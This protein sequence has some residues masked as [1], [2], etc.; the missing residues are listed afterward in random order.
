MKKTMDKPE[1]NETDLKDM[2]GVNQLARSGDRRLKV[3]CYAVKDALLSIYAEPDGF[4][5]QIWE[6]EGNECVKCGE[7]WMSCDC[8]ETI[9][10]THAVHKHILERMKI[11]ESV[12]HRPTPEFYYFNAKF[13]SEKH[14]PNFF[15]GGFQIKNTIEG[16]TKTPQGF[17]R[18][19]AFNSLKRLCRKFKPILRKK[20]PK[21]TRDKFW[22]LNL[23]SCME[24]EFYF[25]SARLP[26]EV[27]AC[28]GCGKK[29]WLR[30]W[31][32][33]DDMEQPHER[34][35]QLLL[36]NRYNTECD[37]NCYLPLQ[38]QKT[39]WERI[40]KWLDNQ[41]ALYFATGD[42]VPMKFELER[43]GQKRLFETA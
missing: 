34:F 14:S 4:D 33:D 19:T 1:F 2:V 36:P 42:Y 18:K 40:E 15:G 24:E 31:N 8:K 5:L 37:G 30:A 39:D 29:V 35:P 21:K 28:R 7:F 6:D 3:G 12:F 13:N 23:D 26:E 10:E 32:T 16:K 20:F 43:A 41:F 17:D 25:E 22:Y 38:I 9:L 11:G 27:Y